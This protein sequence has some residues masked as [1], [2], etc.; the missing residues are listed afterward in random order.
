MN[1]PFAADDDWTSL[2]REL[3]VPQDEPP[4]LPQEEFAPSAEVEG[5]ESLDG[6]EPGAEGPLAEATNGDEPRK[7]RRQRRRRRRNE[8][9]TET[10]AGEEIGDESESDDG[11]SLASPSEMSMD[12]LANWD[13]PSWET[14]VTT[15]LYRPR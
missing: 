6:D 4:P 1:D 9:G 13:V 5:E 15:M 10:E 7:K 14:I 11:E 12:V 3:G 2:A 8:D